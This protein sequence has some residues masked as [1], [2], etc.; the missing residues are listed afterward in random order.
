M[1]NNRNYFIFSIPKTFVFMLF[2]VFSLTVFSQK[3]K[4]ENKETK[5]GV[6][7]VFVYNKSKSKTA[8]SDATGV[9]DL[10]SFLKRDTLI[11]THQSYATFVIQK[12]NIGNTISL[13]QMYQMCGNVLELKNDNSQNFTVLS[14]T[15][16]NSFKTEQ[17][18][19]IHKHTK[20]IVCNIPNIENVGGGSARCMIA[21]VFY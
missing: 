9:I 15:A 6:D 14:A 18:Q 12:I 19:V 1:Q 5:V 20:R 8:V 3:I 4:I 13:K 7:G 16:N 2:F 10:S 17:L 21:E 11:F